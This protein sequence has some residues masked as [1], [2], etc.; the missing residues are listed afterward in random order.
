MHKQ[1]TI[2]HATLTLYVRPRLSSNFSTYIFLLYF[3]NIVFNL[4]NETNFLPL[5]FFHALYLSFYL[6]NP[7][8]LTLTDL[9]L[10]SVQK[11]LEL[12][13]HFYPRLYG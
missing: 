6:F 3:H 8:I 5:P 10:R 9:I 1:N 11:I 2:I 4:T 7:L 13:H 12:Y